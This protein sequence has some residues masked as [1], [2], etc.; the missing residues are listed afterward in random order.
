MCILCVIAL[1]R[2]Q[3]T[4]NDIAIYVAEHKPNVVKKHVK[5]KIDC[6]F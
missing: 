4:L 5:F 1:K 3:H 2:T 6:L